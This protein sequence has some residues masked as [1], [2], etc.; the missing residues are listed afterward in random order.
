[1]RLP[2]IRW[3]APGPYE[4]AFSTRIGGVSEPPYDSLN[5]GIM[6]GDEPARVLENR[7]RLCY[8]VDVD[9]ERGQMAWQQHGPVVR[10]AEPAG[11]ATLADRP[12]CDGLWS[13]EPGLGMMLVAADCLPIALGRVNGV[14][15]AVAV[16]HV[17]WKGL[18]GGIVAAGAAALGCRSAAVIGPGIGPCCYEVRDDVAAPYRAAFGAEVVR[19]GRL[20]MWSAAERALS[21]AGCSRVERIDLCTS[22]QPE[23]FFSHRRDGPRTGRQGVIAA[24]A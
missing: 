9:A 13:E 15:P 21:E 24:V 17:G 12:P 18:L 10:R 11:L 2:L 5:L 1:V 7:R 14:R 16:L 8:E 3:E 19:D 6:T 22:C 4:V 20:D 23:L